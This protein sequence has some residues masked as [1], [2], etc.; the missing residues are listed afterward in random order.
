MTPLPA[1]PFGDHQISRLIVGS[2][3]E[4][5]R[6]WRAGLLP[7]LRKLL[8]PFPTTHCDLQTSVV[9]S[10]R[11]DGYMQHRIA[12]QTRPGVT[13]PAYLLIPDNPLSPPCPAVVCAHGHVPGGKEVKD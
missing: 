7:E 11:R 6:E 10:E 5:W 3:K 1:I 13:V 4:D 2:T 12:Y 9:E 8:G